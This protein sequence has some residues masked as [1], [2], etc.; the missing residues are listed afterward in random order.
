ML[1]NDRMR[2][3][4]P[5]LQVGNSQPQMMVVSDVDGKTVYLCIGQASS[6]VLHQ[7]DIVPLS[8]FPPRICFPGDTLTPKYQMDCYWDPLYLNLLLGG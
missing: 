3:I 5:L 8:H 6:R 4:I 7:G 1:L 2:D